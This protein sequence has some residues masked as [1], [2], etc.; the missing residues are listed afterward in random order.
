MAPTDP[1]GRAFSFVIRRSCRLPALLI[2][3]AFLLL[4]DCSVIKAPYYVV[5]GTIKGGYYAVKGTYEL[6]AGTTKIVYTI[7]KYTFK[8]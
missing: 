8:W 4:A 6:T 1:A 3:P 2:V 5:K 7:G